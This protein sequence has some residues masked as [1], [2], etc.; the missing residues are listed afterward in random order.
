MAVGAQ[1]DTS[2]RETSGDAKIPLLNGGEVHEATRV[3]TTEVKKKSEESGSTST[4]TENVVEKGEVEATKEGEK[5]KNE[6][7]KDSDKNEKETD[8][9]KN[10]SNEQEVVLIQ[11][12]GFT[13]KIVSPGSEPFD[14]QVSSMELVQEIHQLLMDREDTC[15]RTCFSLQLDGNTLDNFAEL[16]NIEGLKDGS[17]IKVVEEP[18]TMREARIHVRHVR[19]LL[20]SVDPAD[21]YNGVECSSLSFLNVV[22]NGDILE[23]KKTRADSVD[24]TPPDYIIPGCSR[25]R[26]LLPLQ[27]QAKEQKCP[28]CLKVLTTSGWNPPPGH[29]KLH[30]D[31]MYLHVVTLEDKQ[32]Y[33]TAC[34]RGFF[35]NQSTKEVFNPKPATPSHLCHSLIEL[36]NQLS[37][38]FK[39]AFASMQRRRTQ[40]HPFER[41]ATPYQLYA[42]SAPQIEHTIDA[43]RAEDTFS[44]KLGYEEHIP[45]QTRDWNEELQTTRE[46]PRKNLPERLLRERAIF[47]VHSDFV[48]AATRGAMAVIDGN[49]M[50]INPGEEAKMQMFIWNNIFF[51]LGFDVR[52]HYKELGGDAAAFIAPRNDLQGVRVYAAVDLHG[53]YT[54][55]TVVIDYR[56]YRVTAQ[57]IIPGI[58]EREQEQSV[59]Y[60]SI[61]FG[62]TVLTHP[63]YLELLNKAGQQLKILPH[64]V[65]NDAGDEIE[66]CSS[67]ECKGIIGNDSRHYVL[68]LLR[69][70][71]PDVN[72]LKLEGVEL[73]KEAR[74]LGF[75]IEH[76]HRLACLRQELID[77][78]V[79]SRYVQFIKH[80]AVHLQQ[81]TSA[82]RSQ[83]EKEATVKEDKK[84]DKKEDST[85]VVT[86]DSNKEDCA[87][88]II[89][90]DE[91]KKIVESITDSITGGEKQEL[92]ESTKEIVRRAA[93]AVGSLRDA[94]FDVRFN[95]DVFSPGVKHPDPN[96][97]DL[98]KQKQLVKDAADF[99]LTVQLPTFI[100]ECLDHT[101]AAMDGSTLVEA[102]H[103]R[104]IN[105]RY[106]G[107]LAAMLAAV[108][109]LQYLNRIAVSE[110]ILRS[111]K[112]IFTSYMQ[113]TELMSLSAAVSHFLNCLLSSAQII[114][115]QQN[116]EELQSKT[117]KRRNKRK[118]R[119]NG[120]QQSEVEWASL[121]PKSLWQQIKGDLK[122]YYDWETPS[123]ESLE[124]TIEH[125]H[126]QKI[127]LLRSFC[128][129]TG[130]QI[131]LREYNFE[132]KNRATFFEEDILNIFPVVKHIN[133]R[134]SDAYNFYTTGQ[135]KI[136]QGYLK[137]GY[138]LISEALN[139]L[140]N[141]YGAM[142]PEIAQ[143]LRM[144]ARLNYIMGD[145]AEALATQQKAVLMSERVNGID[146]PYTITEYIHLA[147]YS[148]ANGQVSVSLRLLY[149]ARYLALLVCGEDHPE[150]ALL[151]SNI[152]LILH[153]V[154]EYELSLR[155]LE[156]ALALNL[157]Y[158]GPHSLK[159]AVSYHLVARTQS[160]MGDFRAALNNE[161]ETYAIYKQLLGEEHEKTKESSDCLRHLTQQAVVLQKKMNEI[162][163]GKSGISL[164]P[165]QVQPPSMGSVLDM[166][167]VIN[168][169]LFV[170]ISQQD[171]DN[172]KA[173]IEKRQKEQ[174]P[175][176][177]ETVIAITEKDNKEIKKI[178]EKKVEVEQKITK[179]LEANKTG[180]LES[181]VAT[182][183]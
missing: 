27:P 44:S 116:L 88:S 31:L 161:K 72:F 19:D 113:G 136:T 177:G 117:A 138:E 59:V 43:I 120:P 25:D 56:G 29:R 92:E 34:A 24:C 142:H 73:S 83:K 3:A 114:H 170:Q 145:H 52:D 134:A 76:K 46:L 118:G 157:R 108:P 40:R 6:D 115:P 94:E 60:G 179:D 8:K 41:V 70:F 17:I 33:L 130:I 174:S 173:E 167:N 9:E 182:K 68:D 53:L 123:P 106:L 67:V 42:W 165:I 158:H 36:L 172:F 140:N 39:R 2:E 135:N 20:K 15:H 149:R 156:H 82:R 171:I 168:G 1:I 97:S 160:C 13:V 107:K 152:S 125:F 162:Y 48:A 100:R 26:P 105:V 111:A 154:G 180:A 58:L 129:K 95:P 14:I 150:V 124:A 84:E 133:P 102:L 163:T 5:E 122:A 11:D 148:F 104:G 121:T 28:P 109:Q 18:Y 7:N 4:A 69:T 79:E 98:K 62:K 16:K 12:L 155:F 178:V 143:C 126:L 110:L 128:I 32:Y 181:I 90:A 51:S 49:V 153:A 22:T 89:E 54:L 144:L 66:L 10:T 139:L 55:G 75:P 141:V 81:L 183:S 78:F 175:E 146:H 132:N 47:K 77:S 137:D 50:A 87:Q 101:G 166:L 23:K 93:A 147:L 127:S 64:K 35:V 169:I 57:S 96:G 37:P 21:A 164:P 103:G 61:D 151:D 38:S 80:A 91:A 112:H 30:G 131:L 45:G 65:I 63:K 86:V 99:L 85:A 159:V 176:N 74:A 119:N 71:P